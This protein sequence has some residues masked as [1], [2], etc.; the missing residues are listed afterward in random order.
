MSD[1]SHIDRIFKEGLGER[2]F[3][4][5]DAMWQQM[6]TELDKEDKKRRRPFVFF[7]LL[8]SLITTSI[9][10]V[11]HF[12]KPS[13]VLAENK[14]SLPVTSGDNNIA[15]TINSVGLNSVANKPVVN[16]NIIPNRRK[17]IVS[18]IAAKGKTI[19]LRK[20]IIEVSGG[21]V[22]DVSLIEDETLTVGA[23]GPNGLQE[24]IFTSVDLIGAAQ[25]ATNKIKIKASQK[26]MTG[27]PS[28]L[29]KRG[30][31]PV[32]NKLVIEGIIGR[33]FLR[34]N[35][36]PA[37]YAGVRFNK[38]V[39]AGTVI[40]AGL[41]Y[42]S[43]N[44]LDRYRLNIKQ[45]GEPQPQAKVN[46]ISTLRM[47]VYLQR[48]MGKSKFSIMAGLVPSYV[49]SADIYNLPDSY[50]GSNPE[51]QR[52]F[53]IADMHRFNVLF[54]AGIKYS[55]YKWIALEVSGSYGLTGLVKNAY[56]NQSRVN[57]NFK[58]IQV[59]AAFRLK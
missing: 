28:L 1:N 9:F 49:L 47:P 39:D 25:L 53:T 16:S 33:D 32:K 17:N 54:G 20:N 34:M 11:Q 38:Q 27:G 44:L 5:T 48:Q 40:S 19:S 23:S 52:R 3:S 55:P 57:D 10:I 58:S 30:L 7:L 12:N 56:K 42:A 2:N 36:K 6:E 31:S 13:V 46:N 45:T 41:T 22:G 14:N 37:I 50:S 26:K 29:A 35:R 15:A 4:S 43:H 21:S 51:T 8:A 59:G 24:K 18:I